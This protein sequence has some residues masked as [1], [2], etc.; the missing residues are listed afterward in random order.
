MLNFSISN[1][2]TSARWPTSLCLSTGGMQMSQTTFLSLLHGD[3]NYDGSFKTRN[4]FF[5]DINYVKEVVDFN[6]GSRMVLS[7]IMVPFSHF[8]M[9][10]WLI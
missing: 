5:I 6:G 7:G 2:A 1:E 3:F 8:S 10:L 4:C 9:K